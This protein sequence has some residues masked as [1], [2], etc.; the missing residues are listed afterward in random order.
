MKRKSPLNNGI[1]NTRD[2]IFFLMLFLFLFNGIKTEAQEQNKENRSREFYFSWGYNADKYT[3]TSI[4][5]S[6]P[7]LGNDYVFNNIQGHDYK[8]WD[9]R[10]LHKDLTIPQYNYRLGYWFN[11][12]KGLAF[13]I[14][15]DHTKFIVTQGQTAHL[16]GLFHGKQTDSLINFSWPRWEYFLNNG[17]NFFCLNI[18]KQMPIWETK[19]HNFKLDFLGKIGAGPVTPHV[20][21]ILDSMHNHPH[22]QIGGWNAGIEGC[23]KLTFG[24][25]VYLEYTNKLDYARYSGL[26]VYFG[27]AHQAFGCYEM[28]LNLGVNFRLGKRNLREAPR[29]IKAEDR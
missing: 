8:G 16:T 5:I 14:S 20:Q 25:Y 2:A 23:I 18:V 19:N 1:L 4:H 24:K 22:F 11:K 9:N 21:D 10:I 7:T 17:A 15:F 26:R 28:I 29:V 13:E 6:Q 3:E 12:E 27:T